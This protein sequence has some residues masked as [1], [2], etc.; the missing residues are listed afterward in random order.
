MLH[1]KWLSW[2][3]IAQIISLLLVTL[4]LTSL[5]Y[6]STTPALPQ[7]IANLLAV[8]LAIPAYLI[9]YNRLV[10][11][12]LFKQ[13]FGLFILYTILVILAAATATYIVAMPAYHLLSGQ[14][15]F[16]NLYYFIAIFG[17]FIIIN[18][19]SAVLGVVVKIFSNRRAMEKQLH[20]IEKEKINTELNFLRSQV[21]PHFLFN[22]LNTIY[23]QISQENL[24]ARNSVEKF[25]EMLRYQLYECITDKINIESEVE[26]IK[27]YVAM[28]TL[29]LEKDTD[30][31]LHCDTNLAG[32]HIA[33]LLLLPVIEN[34]FKHISSYK[35][36]FE[37]KIHIS[38]KNQ[39]P[40]F[41][42][43]VINTYNKVVSVKY[44]TGS[45]GLG[46]QNLRRR[47]GLLYP[48][49]YSLNINQL[50]NTFEAT[51]KIQYDD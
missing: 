8:F 50:E 51:L 27:N 12:F 47:L 9:E 14:P 2:Y 10:P 30:I 42:L 21:N 35:N 38:L 7:A 26:Y 15:I 20:E 37:N 34:A 33:P 1:K 39:H 28:Q 19:I 40:Y 11:K 43:Q 44:I 6:D 25:S 3:R 29:R 24:Q 18:I 17:F 22:I 13:R 32:F 16:R 4:F 36:A 45:G 23:F 49:R 48:E 31:R 5:N 46:L 41:I